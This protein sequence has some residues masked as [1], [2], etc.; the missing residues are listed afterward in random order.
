[1]TVDARAPRGRRAL[2]RALPLVVG[3]PLLALVIA[4]MCWH[5]VRATGLAP[6]RPGAQA[7]VSAPVADHAPVAAADSRI[8][9]A[10]DGSAAGVESSRGQ[11]TYAPVRAVTGAGAELA[12]VALP[13]TG[14]VPVSGARPAVTGQRAPPTFPV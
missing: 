6:A 11:V 13:A 1:M 8:A 2:R 7:L 12:A 10:S 5:S 14:E 4:A 9:G 3:L